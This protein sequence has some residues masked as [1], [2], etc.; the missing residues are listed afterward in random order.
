MRKKYIYYNDDRIYAIYFQRSDTI[1]YNL[2]FSG[3]T[4]LIIYK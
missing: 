2:D 1:Y 4:R 3:F